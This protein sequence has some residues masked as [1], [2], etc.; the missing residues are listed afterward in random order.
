MTL[1]LKRSGELSVTMLADGVD[2]HLPVLLVQF[3][4][5]LHVVHKPYGGEE[6]GREQKSTHFAPVTPKALQTPRWK[7]LVFF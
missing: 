5:V 7:V 2:I 1:Q 4:V 6:R 3:N